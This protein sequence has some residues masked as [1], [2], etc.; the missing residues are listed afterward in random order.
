MGRQPHCC[1]FIALLTDENS[2]SA[3]DCVHRAAAA[4]TPFYCSVLISC[5][6]LESADHTSRVDERPTDTADSPDVDA[7]LAER[8]LT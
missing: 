7:V 2:R 1:P 6:L 4:L 3:V 5:G 8:R